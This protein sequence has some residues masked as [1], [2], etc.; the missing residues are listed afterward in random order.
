MLRV[1]KYAV[2]S[3]HADELEAVAQIDRSAFDDFRPLPP[4]I[5]HSWHA[6]YPEGF[7]VAIDPKGRIVGYGMAIRLQRRRIKHN[8][9]TDT[10]SGTCQTH[11]PTG[12][13]LYG[14]SLASLARGAGAALCLAER[15][16][17]EA[18]DGIKEIWLYARLKEFAVWKRQSASGEDMAGALD[19]YIAQRRDPVA[20]FYETV[21][22]MLM[23]G[24]MG[25]LPEDR[26]SLGCAVRTAWR[27]PQQVRKVTMPR[28]ANP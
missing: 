4:E 25:Y 26:D 1:G 8:W 24:V 13:I 14:V 21:G 11:D 23:E 12:D 20:I 6:V 10:D 16:L 19:Q 27:K 5:F 2:R 7:K 17:V 15:H 9:Y 18:T 28:V 22:L 3:V